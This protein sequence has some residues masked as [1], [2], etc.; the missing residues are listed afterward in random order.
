[1]ETDDDP[2]ADDDGSQPEPGR[3]EWLARHAFPDVELAVAMRCVRPVRPG[4]LAQPDTV[5]AVQSR[6]GMIALYR[7]SVLAR[8]EM[9]GRRPRPDERPRERHS[10]PRILGAV[11][12]EQLAKLDP[13]SVPHRFGMWRGA[14]PGA[15]G[16]GEIS[17]PERDE[18]RD[19]LKG[20]ER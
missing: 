2:W 14:G 8:P 3:A 20:R 17:D 11:D 10:P 16:P 9:L 4:E 12:L 19:R 18:A 6:R 15:K 1:M 7:A 13:S 5:I